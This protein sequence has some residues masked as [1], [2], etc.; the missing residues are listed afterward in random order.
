MPPGTAAPKLGT[1][2]RVES[3]LR[4]NP[5]FNEDITVIKET[6]IRETLRFQLKLELLNAFNRHAWAL[7]DVTPTDNLFGVPTSTL[8]T[9]R[10][11]QL[12]ARLLF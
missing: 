5:Y 7:P 1:L 10:N 11:T 9:P 2:P 12:T 3:A 4:M 6:P 8:T